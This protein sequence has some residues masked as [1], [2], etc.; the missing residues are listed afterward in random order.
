M[1]VLDTMRIQSL[2]DCIPGIHVLWSSG[3]IWHGIRAEA[4]HIEEVE[5]GHFQMAD[6]GLL[7]HLSNSAMVELEIDGQWDKRMRVPGDLCILPE[8]AISRVRSRDPHDALILTVSQGLIARTGLDAGETMAA[9]LIGRAHLRD[10]ALEHICRALNAEAEGNYGSSPLYGECLGVALCARL[11]QVSFVERPPMPQKGGIT[12]R[13][14]RRVLDHVESNLDSLLTV[15]CLAKISGL[16]ECRFAHNFKYA[17]G[18]PPHQYVIQMRLRRA[19]EMLRST[20]LAVLDIANA[21]G[22]VS[23]SRFNSLFRRELGITPSD[24]RDCF[25]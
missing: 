5:T 17:T 6:H 20:N 22:Y 18:L 7:F 3:A 16:S 21:V 1:P 15:A 12:P 2:T 8:T 23:V 11:L 24:Y 19:K 4:Y 13:T 14:L 25:R 10:A 9:G